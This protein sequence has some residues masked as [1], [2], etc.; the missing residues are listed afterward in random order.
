MHRLYVLGRI[1]LRDATGRDVRTVTAQPKRLALLAYLAANTG[2]AGCRRDRLLGL[3]WPE[4]DEQRARK[5]LNKAVHFLRREVGGEAL[6]SRN[7]DE[8]EVDATRLWCDAGAFQSAVNAG[9]RAQ[10]LDLYGGDL[11]PSFYV[12]DAPAFDE[13]M[14]QERTRLRVVAAGAARAL[15]TEREQEGKA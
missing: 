14:E 15:A 4:L 10:A 1:D 8:I 5:A 11:L 6:V 12:D 3:F 7:G 9:D 13:W 2:T